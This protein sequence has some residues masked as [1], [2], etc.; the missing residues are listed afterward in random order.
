MVHR[1]V[2]VRDL[3]KLGDYRNDLHFNLRRRQTES[4]TGSQEFVSS[5]YTQGHGPEKILWEA[6]KQ[7]LS[8][9]IGWVHFTIDALRNKISQTLKEFRTFLPSSIVE[10][11]SKLMDKGQLVQHI[12][13]QRQI[14]IKLSATFSSAG[15]L[16]TRW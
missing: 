10:E 14:R 11:V 13:G 2:Y 9:R 16:T 15:K 5:F 1:L 4:H 8:K 12:K 3:G 7:L 6:Q